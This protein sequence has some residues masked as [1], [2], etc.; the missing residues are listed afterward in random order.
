MSSITTMLVKSP[1]AKP[2]SSP[3]KSIMSWRSTRKPMLVTSG[4]LAKP[5]GVPSALSRC[6]ISVKSALKSAIGVNCEASSWSKARTVPS[7]S[8]LPIQHTTRVA[9]RDSAISIWLPVLGNSTRSVSVSMSKM[10]K[11][12]AGSFKSAFTSAPETARLALRTKGRRRNRSVVSPTRPKGV[13]TMSGKAK[14][15]PIC[16]AMRLR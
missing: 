3:T 4:M 15:L 14:G 1:S 11:A 10:P 13:G 2:K 5:L 8:L 9:A 12:S 7:T 16:P 6:A